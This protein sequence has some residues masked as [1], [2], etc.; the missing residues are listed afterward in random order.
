ML[1]K[2]TSASCLSF[3]SDADY[4]LKQ[5]LLALGIALDITNGH[6]SYTKDFN[7]KANFDL[8]FIRHGETF[9][10]CGQVSS[11][12]EIDA[13][14]VA[15]NIKNTHQRIFQ[16]NVDAPINQLTKYGKKQAEEVAINI[17]NLFLEQG[18]SHDNVSVYVSP[19]QR[20]LDTAR[21]FLNFLNEN[22]Y[23]YQYVICPEIREMS[24]GAWDNR[25]IC[26]FEEE[27]ACHIF[28]RQQNAL[29]KESGLNGNGISQS[30]ES[31]CD[32]ILRAYE[33][34]STLNTLEKNKKVLMFSH[35]LFG[36]ACCILL[37]KGQTIENE[38]YLAFDGHRSDGTSYLIPN[39][40]P[41]ILN[42][43]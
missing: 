4:I 43:Y 10:N 9:G 26:D 21:P 15:G 2:T 12:G 17:N 29:I 14:F 19:L 38:N 16:G 25:R 31:F 27:N 3:L 32:V 20:A 42:K 7:F 11:E 33:V 6:L 22:K 37:G 5:K 13:T 28:Y 35:S 1:K 34:L 18:W 41:V 36:A 39:A 23:A 40:R 24:F 30:A 8:I